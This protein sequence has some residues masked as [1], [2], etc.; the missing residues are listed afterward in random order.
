M[1]TVGYLA[2]PKASP[3]VGDHAI[4]ITMLVKSF[5]LP[6]PANMSNLRY[7]PLNR[8][9]LIRLLS[10]C[11]LIRLWIWIIFDS[12]STLCKLNEIKYA[13]IIPFSFANVN[14]FFSPAYLFNSSCI[15]NLPNFSLFKIFWS[16]LKPSACIIFPM[17]P[18]DIVIINQ[19]KP[20]CLPR[21]KEAS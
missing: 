3:P 15:L 16:E 18:N 1:T 20:G 6:L 4:F 8:L 14:T 7:F 17:S 12:K 13:G 2:K 5:S 21:G 19:T 10:L 11:I 9:C